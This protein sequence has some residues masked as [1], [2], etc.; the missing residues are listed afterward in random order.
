MD[1]IQLLSDVART[2]LFFA[3]I[4]GRYWGF[5]RLTR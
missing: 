5:L 4:I 1:F 2:I 3:L